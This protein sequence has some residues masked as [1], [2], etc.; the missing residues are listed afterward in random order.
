M[1]ARVYLREAV[2]PLAQLLA[3]LLAHQDY[4]RALER[5]A[6][7]TGHVEVDFGR[8]GLKAGV[9]GRDNCK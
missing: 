5:E 7:S 2:F 6:L 8:R 1:F 3:E 9:G 4:P